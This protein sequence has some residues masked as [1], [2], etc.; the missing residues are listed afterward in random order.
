[1]SF[2]FDYEDVTT[3]YMLCQVIDLQTCIKYDQCLIVLTNILMYQGIS[4]SRHKLV[5][6]GFVLELVEIVLEQIDELFQWDLNQ[7][8]CLILQQHKS[9]VICHQTIL[10]IHLGVFT[11]GPKQPKY[12][13]LSL[14][15]FASHVLVERE[16]VCVSKMLVSILFLLY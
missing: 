3:Y 15:G 8:Q 11:G 10:K 1:M 9:L 7:L 2:G 16:S 5:C 13:N 4:I 14:S 12:C 6:W